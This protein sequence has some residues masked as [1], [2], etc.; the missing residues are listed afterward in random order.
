MVEHEIGRS[1]VL[2]KREDK[3]VA[4]RYELDRARKVL[5]LLPTDMQNKKVLD[6]GCGLGTCIKLL[7]DR[8]AQC[9]GIDLFCEGQDVIKFDLNSGPL[10]LEDEGYDV[11]ICTDVLEHLFYPHFTLLEIKRV[12]RDSG[13]AIISL[14]NEFNVISRIRILLGK[15]ISDEF[16]FDSYGHHYFPTIEQIRRFVETEFRIIDQ[17][18]QLL[19]G[20]ERFVGYFLQW[21]R[22]NLGVASLIMKCMKR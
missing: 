6:V 2:K 14:P 11:V 20:R 5:E 9:V 12:L 4:T 22:T 1:R 15:R 17:R 7:S 16:D 10:P 3:G 8:G 18:Y 21:T 13:T 19:G